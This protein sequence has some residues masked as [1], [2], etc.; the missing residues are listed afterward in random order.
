M[1]W[2]LHANCSTLPT[3]TFFMPDTEGMPDAE[4]AI[5]QG[6]YQ[7]TVSWLRR[8][9]CRPCAVWQEC[10]LASLPELGGMWAGVTEGKRRAHRYLYTGADTDTS[11]D[12]LLVQVHRALD[13]ID[14][15]MEWHEALRSE[16]LEDNEYLNDF[17]KPCTVRRGRPPKQ[18]TSEEAA[19]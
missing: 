4:R 6:E 11:V 13:R 10:R 9:V 15:G 8:E 7:R 19:A 16:G 17:D 18:A 3:E 12:D 2:R 14:A 5:I 1:T